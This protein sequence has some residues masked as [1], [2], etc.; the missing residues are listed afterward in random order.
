MEN[1]LMESY[2]SHY[3]G[4]F[5]FTSQKLLLLLVVLLHSLKQLQH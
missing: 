2:V 1:Y 4:L 3:G 5:I